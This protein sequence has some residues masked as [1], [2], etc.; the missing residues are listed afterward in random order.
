MGF[1]AKITSAVTGNLAG[2]IFDTV[3]AYFPPSMSDKE[4]GQ[5]QF[6]LQQLEDKRKAQ[7][8]KAETEAQQQFN[9][10]VKELEGTAA[11]LKTIPFIGA[12]IIFLRGCQRPAWSFLTMYMDVMWFTVWQLNDQQQKALI[13]I[14]FLVLG[15]LFGERTIKNLEPLLLKLL[16]NRQKE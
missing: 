16:G 9:N 2:E 4:K 8:E 10:R 12:F 15:F 7:A 14:N 11:D 5:M 3:K 6:A 13:V 1:F